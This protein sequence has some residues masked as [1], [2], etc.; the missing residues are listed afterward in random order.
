MSTPLRIVPADG[1]D[2][3]SLAAL[4]GRVYEGYPV[5]VHMD[6]AI[7]GLMVECYDESLADSVVLEADGEPVALALLAVRPPRGW[8]GGMGVAA[9]H[10]RRGLGR[11]VMQALIDR[12]RG[13]G[14]TELWLEVLEMNESAHALYRALGFR[15][16][17]AVDVWSIPAASDAEALV[18]RSPAS[19]EGAALEPEPWQRSAATRARFAQRPPGVE[20]LALRHAGIEGTITWR[21]NGEARSLLDARGGGDAEW[22]SRALPQALAAQEARTLRLLNVA[23]GGVL[24]EAARLAGGT[25]DTGQWEMC[26]PL[27]AD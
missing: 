22:W 26:L 27:T 18:L 16:V 1:F 6:E 17:R 13:R 9:S 5:A 24:A 14:L 2:L 15:D 19:P 12:A 3:A 4:F 21:P 8:V 20:H 11:Q 23:S 10:R 25:R 7:L